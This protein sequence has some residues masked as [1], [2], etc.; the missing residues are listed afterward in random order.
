FKLFGLIFWAA[1]I[2]STIGAA[3][4]SVSFFTAFKKNLT[5]KQTNYTSKI[6]WRMGGM[7]AA[8]Q[9]QYEIFKDFRAKNP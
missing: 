9:M 3:Y 7:I 4:T 5:P 8:V 1:G 2:S 6:S